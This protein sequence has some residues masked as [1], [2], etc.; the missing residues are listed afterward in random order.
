MHINDLSDRETKKFDW[1][2]CIKSQIQFINISI[3]ILINGKIISV[4]YYIHING[5]KNVHVYVPIYISTI[6]SATDNYRFNWLC[7][8]SYL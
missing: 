4:I 6:T 8:S 5:L 3:L 1:W 2:S 7:E